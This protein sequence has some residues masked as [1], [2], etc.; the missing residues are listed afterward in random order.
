MET[1]SRTG[2]EQP[3]PPVATFVESALGEL[4]WSAR[5]RRWEGTLGELRF[6]LM[7][8]HALPGEALVA[9]AHDVLGSL[10]LVNRIAERAKADADAALRIR[11]LVFVDALDGPSTIAC[12]VDE[13][14]GSLFTLELTGWKSHGLRS[15]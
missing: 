9:Y 8:E 3:G 1:S 13:R 12:F 4:R 5:E 15:A 11:E 2:K 10:D 6:A 14:S 7:P